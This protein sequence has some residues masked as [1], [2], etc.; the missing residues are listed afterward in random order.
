M[1]QEKDVKY[2]LKYKK[3]FLYYIILFI[4]SRLALVK[5]EKAR[6]IEDMIIQNGSMGVY[7]GKISESELIGFLEGMEDHQDT[8]ISFKRKV[9]SDDDL[10]IDNIWM[11]NMSKKFFWYFKLNN[12]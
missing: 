4:V 3:I 10:D 5:P 9:D 2:L 8:K 12:L 1:K 6:Q 7:K 11:D